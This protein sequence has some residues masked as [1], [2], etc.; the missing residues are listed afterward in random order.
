MKTS[1]IEL[2]QIIIHY[3]RSKHF[4]MLYLIDGEL[5]QSR[6]SIVQSMKVRYIF[7]V[8]LDFGS[9][10]SAST[11]TMVWKLL[12]FAILQHATASNTT[13]TLVVITAMIESW[14]QGGSVVLKLISGILTYTD[15][16]YTS[17]TLAQ[18][19]MQIKMGLDGTVK[20]TRSSMPLENHAQSEVCLQGSDSC[21]VFQGSKWCTHTEHSSRHTDVR[22][23]YANIG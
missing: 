16:F 13:S 11:I 17:P 1:S 12:L 22:S 8:A 15:S 6:A 20:K 4:W 10:S 3:S 5:A 7:G 21:S 2:I 23:Q 14:G 9:T 18:K 19:L